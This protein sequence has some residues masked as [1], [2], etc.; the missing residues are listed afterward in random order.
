MNNERVFALIAG[1]SPEI[2]ALE[3]DILKKR[4]GLE[5]LEK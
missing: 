4:R 5:E 1:I 2:E 3:E